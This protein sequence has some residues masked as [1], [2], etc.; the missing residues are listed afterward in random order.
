[1]QSWLLLRK[2]LTIFFSLASS[3]PPL[4]HGLHHCI[5]CPRSQAHG[6]PVVIIVPSI[7][8]PHL[9][10]LSQYG[11]VINPDKCQFGVS[12]FD[13][14]GHSISSAGIAPLEECVEAIYNFSA[15]TNMA[16]LQE[17]LGLIHQLLPS[18]LSAL[19]RS[20]PPTIP[21]PQRKEHSLDLDT[22][23]SGHIHQKQRSTIDTYSL[24]H[25]DPSGFMSITV[26]ASNFAVGSVLK[27]KFTANGH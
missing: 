4:V 1:M 21:Y 2:N 6:L 8:S 12:T 11:L 26:D 22:H 19:C 24:G 25:P 5:W 13:F 17:Y 7:T 9:T 15:P 10:D 27:Y 18:L 23:M 16:S 14:L 20:P 3:S